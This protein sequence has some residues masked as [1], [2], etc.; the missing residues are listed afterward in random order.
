MINAFQLFTTIQIV[1]NAIVQQL[2]VLLL[3]VMRL[4]NV[5]ASATLLENNV[6]NVALVTMV[7]QNVS[8]RIFICRCTI[9]D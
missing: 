5:R 8:V 3:D 6:L 7:I 2:A 4:E 1:S 9:H